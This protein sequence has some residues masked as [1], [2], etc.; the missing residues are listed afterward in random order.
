MAHAAREG[1]AKQHIALTQLAW[2]TADEPNP[3]KRVKR[4]SPTHP[5]RTKLPTPPPLPH[6]H[7]HTHTHLRN[8]TKRS[9]KG[10]LGTSHRNSWVRLGRRCP[11][12]YEVGWWRCW[13]WWW[14]G[15]W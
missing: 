8:G 10:V 6:P 3:Y 9:R 1:Y 15:C 12:G 7:T 5:P 13:Q 14:W 4:P 2:G 11:A